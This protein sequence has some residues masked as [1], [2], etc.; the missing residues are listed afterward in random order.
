MN[1]TFFLVLNV[2]FD[3]HEMKFNSN[4][5]FSGYSRSRR[6]VQ[7]RDSF[8]CEKLADLTPKG[9]HFKIVKQDI[10]N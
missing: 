10:Q 9:L 1:I 8:N 7:H 5:N 6:H 4:L 2:L 3:N